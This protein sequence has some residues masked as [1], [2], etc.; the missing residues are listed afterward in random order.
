MAMT[1]KPYLDELPVSSDGQEASLQWAQYL[2]ATFGASG[3]LD[4]LRYYERVG[5]ISDAV[6]RQMT[7]YL[8]G[9]SLD[10]IHNK[11]YDEPATLGEPLG[12]L[13]GTPFAAHAKSLRYIAMVDGTDL[14]SHV[15]LSRM[16]EQRVEG[17]S[18]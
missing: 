5:W 3:A 6:R 18:A 1:P 2:G 15:M 12:T 11:K 10:E 16:A 17:N 9:L 4:A 14:E 7:T 13:T 8:R